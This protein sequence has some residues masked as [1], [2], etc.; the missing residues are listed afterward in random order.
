[1]P[2]VSGGTIMASLVYGG[3]TNMASLVYGGGTNMAS[4]VYG[5]GTNMAD[6]GG[7]CPRSV[8]EQSWHL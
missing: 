3:G 4:L 7:A 1:M 6:G 5:G 2:K 8:G